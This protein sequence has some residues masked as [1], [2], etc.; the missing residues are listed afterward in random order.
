V[1]PRSLTQLTFGKCFN[2]PLAK[3]V[4]PLSLTQLTFGKCF[5]QPLAEGLG[6][7]RGFA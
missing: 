3:G 5:N 4:L 2:Q 1:L 7:L 6:C